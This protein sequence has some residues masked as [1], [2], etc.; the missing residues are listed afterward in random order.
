MTELAQRLANLSPAQRRLLE[1]RLQKN[2]SVAE[3]I[4]IVGLSCRFPGADSVDDYWRIIRD[5]IEATGEIPA[6]RWDVERFFDPSGESPGKMSTRW[7]GFVGGVDQFDPLFFGITPREAVKMDP[8][9]RLLLEVAWEALEYGGLAPER[10]AGSNTGVFVGIG[11]T[12]YS[13]I[14]VPFDD[15][16]EQIDA[17]TGTG[18]ALSI[19]ANRLSYVF[20]FRGPSVAVDT[21]C[22][23]GLVGVHMAVESLRRREC[24]AALAGAVNLILSPETTIAFSKAR[25]LSADGHCR[26]FDSAANGYVRGEGCALLV[27]KRLTDAVQDGDQV[28]AVIRA[29]AVN[30]DG[31]T[32][33]ITAPNARSQQAVIR[34]ALAQAGLVPEQIGYIEAHGTGTPL[35]DPIEVQ[36]LAKVFSRKSAKDRPCYVSSVKAN[37]GHTETV[38]GVA[39]LIKTVLLLG[40]GLIPS[41]LHLRR[42]NPNISLEGTRLEIPTTAVAWPPGAAPRIAGVSSF[43]FGGTNAHV[44]VE[45]AAPP[46]QQTATTGRPLHLLCVSARSAAALQSLADRY[47]RYVSDHP[48]AEAADVCYSANVGRSHFHHRL[49]IAAADTGQLAE[50]LAAVADGRR[51][52]G[53]K[54]G[55]VKI[56]TRPKVAFVFTGQGS[57][58]AGMGRQLYA[59]Q[60]VFR[61]A[62]A[63]CDAILRDCLPRPLL[64]VI[65]PAD[66]A[67]P[68]LDET[69]YT[70]PALFAL[71]FALA[72][73]W[74]SWGIEPDIVLGHSVG[75]YV[76]ACVA[77]V[78][79]LED[80]LRLVFHRARLMQQLPSGGAMA[81]I[82]APV[83]RVAQAVASD[84]RHVAV[85]ARNGPDNTVIAGTAEAVERIASAFQAQ[86]LRIHRLPVSHAFHSP[87]MDPMLDEF[88]RLAE[89]VPYQRPRIPVVSNLTGELLDCEPPTAAYWR[90]HVRNTVR[91]AEG[92]ERLLGEQPH[93]IVEMGPMPVLLGMGRRCVPQ[94]QTRWLP[95]LRQGHDDWSVVLDSLAELYT[96]GVK[97]DW[98]GFDRPWPHR[99]LV[100]PSYPF[101]RQRHWFEP[102]GGARTSAA[103]PAHGPAVHPL[104]GSRLPTPLETTIFQGRLSSR[105]PAWLADH[106]VQG[107]PVTP[108]AA[109]VEQALA[110][111][112]QL[113]GPGHH[114]VENL[115]IQHAMFLTEGGSRAIE[116]T[117]SPE[118]L[119]RRTFESYSVPADAEPSTARWTLHAAGAIVPVAAAAEQDN[120]A[121]SPE[122]ID[123]ESVRRG[124]IDSKSREE[125][126]AMIAQRGLV[127]G[128]AFQVL[129]DLD[130]TTVEAVA[131]VALPVVTSE[132]LPQYHL[133]PA[134]GD[135]CFQAMAL[136]VPLERD[137]SY[138]HYTYMPVSVRR[139]RIHRPL[140]ERMFVHARR[141][142]SGDQPSPETVEGDVHLLDEEGRVLV[143]LE[144]IAVQRVGRGGS[145]G[146]DAA[147]GQ[148]IY[149]LDWQP[150]PLADAAAALADDAAPT[151][152][153]RYAGQNGAA[154]HA[155]CWVILADRQ[156]VGDR[157]AAAS[158]ARGDRAIVVYAGEVDG[159][160]SQADGERFTIDPLNG[161][162]YRRVFQQVLSVQ[163][164]RCAAVVHLWGLDL[165]DP[166]T[167]NQPPL[168]SIRPL[169]CG[170]AVVLIQQMARFS[171]PQPPELWLVSG[172]A[173]PVGDAQGPINV[174]HSPLWGLGRVAAMEHPE[175]SVRL[176]DL[177]RAY[178]AAGA[179]AVLGAELAAAGDEDQVAWR[180]EAR[181]VARLAPDR[182]ELPA[183][184]GAARPLP[185]AQGAFRVRLGSAGSLDS[186]GFEPMEPRPPG[187]G[188]VEIEVRAAGLNFSD[189][190]KAMGLYPGITDAVVPLGIEASGIVTAVGDGVEGFAVGQTV[191][192]VV[193]YAFASHAVTAEYA[194]A[195][196]PEG[197]SHEEA[198]TVPITFL[199]AHYALCRLAQL[200]RGE[201][202]LIHAAAGGVGLAAIQVAQRIGAEVFATAGSPAKRDFVRS[203]GVEHVMDSRT[204]DFAD[205]IREITGRRGVDVVL[206]SLPGEAIARSLSVLAA[207]GR[208]LE[209]GKT[210][211]YQNRMIGLLPFQDNLSYFAIDL[212]RLLRQRHDYVRGLLGEVM[213]HVAAGAYRPLPLARFAID[214]TVDAFRYM[215]QRKNIGK[216]VVSL[217]ER[218]SAADEEADHRLIRP[219]ATYLITGGTGA[220]GLELAE[221]LIR[222]GAHAV[223]LVARRQPSDAARA[224]LERLRQGGARVVVLAG[225]VTDR[226]WLASALAQLPADLPLRG[227]FHAA[228]VLADGLLYDMTA[229]QLAHPMAPKV[230]G[231]WNLHQLTLD[232]PLDLFVLFSSVACIIGSPGQANYAAG[233]AF[234]DALAAWRRRRGLPATA[235]NWGPWAGSGMAAQA[236]REEQLEARGMGLIPP[237]AGLEA[238]ER[239]LRADATEAV[240]IDARWPQILKGLGRRRPPLLAGFASGESSSGPDGSA[241]DQAFLARLEE[242]DAS[243]RR[244]LL[245]EY[246]ADELARIMSLDPSQ[247][248]ADQPLSTLGLDSLMAIELKN[249][250]EARLA[251][252]LPMSRLLEGPS[253]RTLAEHTAELL[254]PDGPQSSEA[255]AAPASPEGWSPLVRLAGDGARAPLFCLHPLGGD[256][257]CYSELA[258]AL[259]GDWTVYALTAR[260]AEGLF[261]PHRSLDELAADY[262]AALRR[263]Q[264]AGPYHLAGW[265]AGGI[266]AFEL[267]HALR[268]QGEETGLLAMFDT[269]LPSIY[270]DVDPE[271]DAQFLVELVNFLNRFTGAAMELSYEKLA[272][273]DTA[274]RFQIALD[275]ARLRG[276]VP[277]EASADFIRRLVEVARAN[278]MLIA[279]YQPAPL[280]HAVQVFRP[281]DMTFLEGVRGEKLDADLGWQRIVGQDTFVHEVPGDHFT[282]MTGPG[283]RVLAERLLECRDQAPAQ[284]PRP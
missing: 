9:Q 39:G 206:N 97:V 83:E 262:I 215:A 277:P 57:Q 146:G 22:S 26:P 145:P 243:G 229:E 109:Y 99:R 253:V 154:G 207:Y 271:D 44:I 214:E 89:D 108:A 112:A 24:D 170:S 191:M 13:K 113:Y 63:Q 125:F 261:D 45:E 221:W 70:Q 149:R 189:V 250:L 228:G 30:Q 134:L 1:Q 75:E 218:K 67:E 150:M 225:D 169:G 276:V 186:L 129:D 284:V 47:R 267:A 179:A 233:N 216:V 190:L 254:Y 119:G 103:G 115:S 248:E 227:V 249:N 12:D 270:D 100:L 246:L 28:L 205:Q 183:R 92:I 181:Y 74:R 94:A 20:D 133:H 252:S 46:P 208:F 178:D 131:R 38:S 15:Y 11:G 217:S 19:A 56:A 3:P 182:H 280:E 260:G 121:D 93:A 240:V 80:G 41:Q 156:G 278:V 166:E 273:A 199:T 66:G 209:I 40:H 265:S 60:P 52:A 201:R 251:F 152:N 281:A 245:R 157:L 264:P 193:P 106:Q 98:S 7:G 196:K 258:K 232:C 96:L 234:L 21:A 174:L 33:G 255:R 256:V 153:G 197:I 68:L 27:L 126:Y 90:Q 79:S 31:R 160:D 188:Q 236:G 77:G 64:S 43:G 257:R 76:A 148:W 159:D 136:V 59:T 104:L 23:S 95:S 124:A 238:L 155:T 73:M 142:S 162:H 111:A 114:A 82:P 151:S 62:L 220:L 34:A 194:L 87:L 247:L 173:Q 4:A 120:P 175:L 2:P 138:S 69:A 172:G 203:L 86:G 6:G 107:S 8:Q 130:R 132:E 48:Q 279:G 85:A 122:P 176:V 202:V 195:L 198:A 180:G 137:G 36:A 164:D 241:V 269:P 118:T 127:Y 51:A 147:V 32:S 167:L 49:A 222:Q 18:N 5:G 168:S 135:A 35:G 50:R 10:M 184:Y 230:D 37:I 213:E 219:G 128:A 42:L 123:L 144:G 223:A 72:T 65:Y 102:K 242:A 55:T 268:R 140:A 165:P 177:D 274:A 116:V 143:E 282:M 259:D 88:E 272:A 84:P 224:R 161:L 211:I 244:E 158:R 237:A 275:E 192:G 231:A 212:D 235:I 61:E 187:P 283:A 110:A 78:F 263:V 54:S 91:F 163:P 200:Q 53:V 204:L 210:D 226:D 81:V 105:W 266:Y 25:M 17:H 101:E 239:L 71:E 141:T 58:Y 185:P 171:W 16:Y 139:V 29:S 14:P 117:I